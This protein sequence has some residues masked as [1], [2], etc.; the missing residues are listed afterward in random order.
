MQEAFDELAHYESLLF[1]GTQRP[2]LVEYESAQGYF[3]IHVCA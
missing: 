2:D 1:E 3:H